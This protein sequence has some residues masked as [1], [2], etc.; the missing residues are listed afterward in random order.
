M[1]VHVLWHLGF[2]TADF[3]N[4]PQIISSSTRKSDSDRYAKKFKTKDHQISM[5]FC[6]FAKCSS[7]R[8]VSG[9]MLG[10]SGKTKHFQLNHIPKRSILSDASKRRA[11][12]VFGNIYKELLRKYGHLISDSRITGV[13]KNRWGLLLAQPLAFLRIF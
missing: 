7:L 12:K 2:R 6:S 9:A 11:S 13:I 5:L 3:F 4:C 1:K 8:E 10:L